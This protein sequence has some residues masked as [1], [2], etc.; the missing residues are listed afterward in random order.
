MKQFKSFP[1]TA[2]PD[3]IEAAYPLVSAMPNG[4]PI[5]DRKLCAAIFEAMWQVAPDS[6]GSGLTQ[7]Q[8]RCHDFIDSYIQENGVSPTYENIKDGI[9]LTARS[10][11]L[12]I[13]KALERRGVL[14]RLGAKAKRNIQL[15]VRPG[16][17]IERKTN[18]AAP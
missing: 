12:R 10:D 3:M 15:L 2:S 18:K 9:Q 11:A 17:Q 1:A 6:R 5:K 16:E 13:V 14:Q 8:Q 4:S 7:L